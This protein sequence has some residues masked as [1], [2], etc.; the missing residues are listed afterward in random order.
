MP[1]VRAI[2]PA[3]LLAVV[4]LS[5]PTASRAAAAP[6]LDVERYALRLIN[7]TRTGGWVRADGSCKGYGSGRH[8]K[9]R[10][11]LRLSAG[12][13]GRVARPYA[14]RIARNDYCGHGLNGSTIRKRFRRAG[15]DGSP[16]GENIGCSWGEPVRD[17]VIRT[18]RYMQ[19]ER[20]YSGWHWRNLKDKDFRLVGIGVAKVDGQI[21]WVTD[22]YHP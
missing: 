5:P 19:A 20:S 7:C 12:L 21:R 3:L 1:I 14:V 18:H 13:S 6:H 11:P 2:L 22:F 15:F 10:P 16:Y 9:Y 17:A 8:S 4:A